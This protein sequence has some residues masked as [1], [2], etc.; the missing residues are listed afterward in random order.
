MT[1]YFRKILTVTALVSVFTNNSFAFADEVTGKSD[2]QLESSRWKARPS[3]T[4]MEIP[5][6]CFEVKKILDEPENKNFDKPYIKNAEFVIPSRYKDFTLPKWKDVKIDEA[7]ELMTDEQLDY[8]DLRKK[9][10]ESPPITQ[11][12][13]V[14]LN[15]DGTNEKVFRFR[16]DDKKRAPE[17]IKYYRCPSSPKGAH[18]IGMEESYLFYYKD[19]VYVVATEGISSIGI[20]KVERN[21]NFYNY[22]RSVICSVGLMPPYKEL[23]GKAF[24]KDYKKMIKSIRKQKK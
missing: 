15:Y 1:K 16:Y 12:A 11:T 14:D 13:E 24:D 4:S 7:K 8:L 2:S 5:E 19:K 18:M 23:A 3:R 22:S 9:N 10:K 20:R 6:V 17:L 21:D